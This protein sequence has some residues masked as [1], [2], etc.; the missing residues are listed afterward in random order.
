MPLR[1]PLFYLAHSRAGD[2]GNTLNLSL[3]PYDEADYELLAE[4]VTPEAVKRHFGPLVEG[5]VVRYELPKLHAFN[6]VL[7]GALQGGVNESLALDT[8]GKSRSSLLLSLLV[9]VP[10]GHRCAKQAVG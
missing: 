9:R 3:I 10:A 8:H 6:F 5:R 7:E 2:K 1:V 4:Q